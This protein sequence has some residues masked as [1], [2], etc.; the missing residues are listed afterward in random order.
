MVNF[1]H[2]YYCSI[3]YFSAPA[4][5]TANCLPEKQRD[6]SSFPTLQECFESIMRAAVPKKRRSKEKRKMR[7]MGHYQTFLQENLKERREICLTCGNF[8]RRGF[9]CGRLHIVKFSSFLSL[10]KVRC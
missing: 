9:L 2:C 8:F 4:L 10:I 6:R 7:K 3:F 1:E 5:A